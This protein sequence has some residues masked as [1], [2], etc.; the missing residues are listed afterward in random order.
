MAFMEETAIVAVDFPKLSS[1]IKASSFVSR[2]GK[3]FATK[4]KKNS[5]SLAE[6]LLSSILIIFDFSEQ[7]K[8]A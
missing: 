6:G 3:L 8:N 7:L 5:K 1:A 4:K 2:A